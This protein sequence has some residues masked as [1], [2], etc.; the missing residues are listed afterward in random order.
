[1]KVVMLLKVAFLA[2]LLLTNPAQAQ[3]AQTTKVYGIATSYTDSKPF[4]RGPETL[5]KILRKVRDFYTEGSGGAHEFIGEVH[6]TTLELRQMRPAGQCQLP[7]RAM[8]SATLREAGINLREYRALLLVVPTS[9][10]GCRGGVQTAFHH[11]EADGTSRIVPLAV[12]WS[13]TDR[14]IAH[15]IVH[16]HGVGHA[17]TLV[18]RNASLAVNCKTKE[19][20]NVLDLMG[21]DGGNFQMIS[22]P[23]RARLGWTEPIVH[24]SGRATYTI[25]AAAK[26][27]SLPTVIEVLLPVAGNEAVKAHQPL[28]LWIEYRAPYGFDKRMGSS[29]FVNFATGAMV[30]LT[31]YWEGTVGQES[32]TVACPPRSP[33]LL[34]MTPKTHTFNDAGL[35]VGQTWTEPFTGTEIAVESH[36]ETTLTVSVSVR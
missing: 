31:G 36:T 29:R 15:E 21:H 7:D 6:P 10:L 20:G 33:C 16:T 27:S 18:C 4:K 23:L 32:R 17:N 9:T 22:A 28:T 30:S 24:V 13:L 19:Y 34:D 25:G 8:L 2:A 11:R 5:R 3:V 26:A 35:A 14:Y 1:M 12:S